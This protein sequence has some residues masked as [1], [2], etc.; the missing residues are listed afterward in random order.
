MMWVGAQYTEVST[1]QLPLLALLS[2]SLRT[3]YQEF[4]NLQC[5]VHP[6]WQPGQE[7][8]LETGKCI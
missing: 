3:L 7:R 1:W 5:I 6:Y 8:L 4:Q 2:Q